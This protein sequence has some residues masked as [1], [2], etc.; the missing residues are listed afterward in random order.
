MAADTLDVVT[1][2][3][4]KTLL[5]LTGTG[6]QYDSELEGWITAASRR[7]DKLVGPVVRRTITDEEHDGGVARIFLYYH[8]IFSITSVT[9]YDG[10]TS[11]TLTAETNASKPD[12]AYK[13]DRYSEDRAYLSSIVN[14]R[15]AGADAVFPTGR[16]NVLVTYVPGR[17]A[18]TAAVDERFKK[19]VGLMLLNFW[20]SQQDSTGQVGEF[21]VPQAIFPTFA[22][23]NSVRELFDGEIQDPTPL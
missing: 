20:R 21:D 22:V 5:N 10:T 17:F 14:R 18:T 12:D 15:S 13:V 11:T 8:P 2:A 16:G 19:G 1:L 23:P 3:E 4:A 7:L 9:E 6:T